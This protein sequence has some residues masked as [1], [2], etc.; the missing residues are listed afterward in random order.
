V[1]QDDI[2]GAPGAGLLEEIIR[3]VKG[4]VVEAERREVVWVQEDVIILRDP[5]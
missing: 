2:A 1:V 3:R 4:R 5:A